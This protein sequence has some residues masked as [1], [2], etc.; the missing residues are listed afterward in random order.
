MSR[1]IVILDSQRNAQMAHSFVDR[2]FQQG[3]YQVEFRL[4]T[5]TS[6]QNAK[7][8]AMLGDIAEQV[9]HNGMKLSPNDWKVL[10]MHALGEEMRIVP[11]WDKTE[12]VPLGRQ[13][14]RLTVQE[15]SDLIEKL[16]QIGAEAGVIWKRESIK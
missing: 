10:G 11:S 3:G 8:W 1:R 7:M 5:R 13:S 6:P 9:E 15:M 4:A 2:C 14:S 16:Y 12:L